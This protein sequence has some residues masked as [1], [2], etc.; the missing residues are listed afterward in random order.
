MPSSARG[1]Q[2]ID[3]V[4]V[5][6]DSG[7]DQSAEE[8][9]RT[10]TALPAGA[11]LA[12]LRT[13]LIREGRFR[14]PLHGASMQPTFPSHCEIEIVPVPTEGPKLGDVLVFMAGDALIAH[15]LVQRSD[16]AWI[17]QGDGRLG[18]D[19]PLHPSQV[20]GKVTAVYQGE[21]CIWPRRAEPVLAAGWVGRH[22]LLRLAR[23]GWRAA[24]R[25]ASR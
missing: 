7:A 15:R 18:S 11:L 14:W 1:R 17:T 20:L 4:G 2:A 23:A 5:M 13:A 16:R 22:R 25:L 12:L 19:P 3:G 9:T 10:A 21:R 24:K 6:P 8:F